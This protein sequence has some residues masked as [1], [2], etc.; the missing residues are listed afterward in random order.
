MNVA[1]A[2]VQVLATEGEEDIAGIF[3]SAVIV[4]R[5]PLFLFQAIQAAL[6]PKLA[7]LAGQGRFRDFRSGLK[8][9]L[10]VVAGLAVAGSI[11]GWIIGPMV[12]KIMTDTDVELGHRTLGLL[13]LGSGVYMLA[14]AMAQAVIALGGHR[15]QA[16][17]WAVGL[18]VFPL[19]VWLSSDDLLFRVE[20]G[21]LAAS[22]VACGAM[23]G[24]L[25]RRL[26]LTG[27]GDVTVDR[28]DVIEALHDVALEP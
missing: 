27:P 1:P 4:A 5:I 15:D 8:R 25:A 6:L 28:G 10:A 14:L 17:A 9:L 7:D 19:V 26:I 18:A 16:F 24:L 22:V 3:V 2:V 21:L 11:G 13:A 23:A 12:V 20:L